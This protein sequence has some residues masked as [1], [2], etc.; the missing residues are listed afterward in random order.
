MPTTYINSITGAQPQPSEQPQNL[1]TVEIFFKYNQ[2]AR[3][4]HCGYTNREAGILVVTAYEGTKRR[5]HIVELR[6]VDSYTYTVESSP[7]LGANDP[8]TSNRIGQ[9]T[10]YGI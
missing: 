1:T 8:L 9:L 4:Y 5:I 7:L 3:I 6:D 2:P 10:T